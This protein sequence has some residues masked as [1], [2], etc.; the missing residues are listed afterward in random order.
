MCYSLRVKGWAGY[1][2]LVWVGLL[3]CAGSSVASAQERT[4]ILVVQDARTLSPELSL[5]EVDFTYR[6]TS[7]DAVDCLSFPR[8]RM[9]Y[10]SIS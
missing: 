4:L 9:G 3:L 5:T 8:R 6:P 10:M 7:T 1:L 2:F